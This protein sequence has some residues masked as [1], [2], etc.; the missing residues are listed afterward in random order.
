VTFTLLNGLTFFFYGLAGPNFGAMA[1]EPMAHIAGTASSVQGFVSTIIA[2]GV[3]LV[4]GQSFSGTTLPLTLGWQIGALVTLAV[5]LFI[6]RGRLFHAH[7][8]RPEKV[9]G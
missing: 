8:A 3:G 1:M 4:I 6:E 7:N 9:G 2:T 5:V